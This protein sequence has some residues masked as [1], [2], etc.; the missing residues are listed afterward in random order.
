MRLPIIALLLAVA[1]CERAPE[2]S[3]NDGW[4]R[5]PAVAGRPGAAYFTIRGGDQPVTLL[6]VSTPSAIRAE[7][8]ESGGEGGMATMRPVQQVDV[9]AG[10]S[11]TFA[12]GGKH[13][14]LFDVDPQ[15]KVGDTAKLSLDFADG[16]TLDVA[17]KVVGPGD[18][19]PTP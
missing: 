3:A 14:M 1:G 9:A 6:K 10:S 2:L 19:A 4:V 18:A 15:L 13:V 7:L 5:L 8:H 12:P 17:A 16:K 11:V